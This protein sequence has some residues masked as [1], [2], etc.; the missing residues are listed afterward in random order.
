LFAQGRSQA[1]V[2]RELDVSRPERQ[3]LACRLASRR[4]AAL[5]TRGPTGRRS[6]IPDSALAEIEQALLEG[7]L[8]HG[9]ATTTP[10]D[11]G[12]DGDDPFSLQY[13]SLVLMNMPPRV[14]VRP[15]C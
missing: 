7:A 14:R 8:A 10:R 15:G 4:A 3:P 2:V 12:P 11:I 13:F 5:R 6:K 1:E 9:F